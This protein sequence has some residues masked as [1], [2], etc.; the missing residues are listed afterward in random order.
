MDKSS[1]PFGQ[2]PYLALPTVLLVI[3]II[4]V[5]I[6]TRH[7]SSSSLLTATNTPTATEVIREACQIIDQTVTHVLLKCEL[8]PR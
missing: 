6:A 7:Q 4:G 3:L 5:T 1:D 2:I 8:G